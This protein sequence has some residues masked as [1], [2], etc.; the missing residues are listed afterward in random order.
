MPNTAPEPTGGAAGGWMSVSRF[1][2]IGFRA[3]GSAFFVRPHEH[4]FTNPFCLQPV[5]G[6]YDM[7]APKSRPCPAKVCSHSFP[8]RFRHCFQ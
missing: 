5:R 2:I 6:N 8:F 1:I 7:A 3:R 4:V